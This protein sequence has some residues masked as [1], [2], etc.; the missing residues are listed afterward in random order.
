[1][2]QSSV[3][4]SPEFAPVSGWIHA[5]EQTGSAKFQKTQ[6]WTTI[7]LKVKYSIND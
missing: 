1:M 3:C 6:E 5:K 7:I 2:L 4:Q